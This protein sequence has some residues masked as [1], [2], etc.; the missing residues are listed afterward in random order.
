M[1]RVLPLG[2]KFYPLR[3]PGAVL[4]L[5][6]RVS[7]SPNPTRNLQPLLPGR[8]CPEILWLGAFAC[9]EEEAG[10][11]VRGDFVAAAEVVCQELGIVPHRRARNCPGDKKAA[12]KI[13]GSSAD[14]WTCLLFPRGD[15]WLSFI[16]QQQI[17]LSFVYHLFL[18]CTPL[19]N[20]LQGF[21]SGEC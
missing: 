16:Q 11:G 15:K 13:A 9:P 8:W 21:S 18:S 10:I 4:Q 1:L 2:P 7:P 14:C 17:H 12:F 19:L 6:A 3:S 5:R 20:T